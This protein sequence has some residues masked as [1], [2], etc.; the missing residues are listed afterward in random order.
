MHFVFIPY[1]M[2]SEVE[3]FVRDME[4]QKHKLFMTKGKKKQFTWIQGQVR[5]LPFG[6][7]EYVCPKDDA[8]TV[9][10]TLQFA[11]NRY[12]VGAF[13]LG[14]MRKMIKVEKIPKYEKKNRS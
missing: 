6:I 3:L 10:N 2:R 11:E 8:D 1:G 7:M 9:L 13:K 5:L 12:D 4:A 14:I